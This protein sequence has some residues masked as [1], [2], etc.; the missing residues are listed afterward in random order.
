MA[1]LLE[2][3]AS[4]ASKQFLA[5]GSNLVSGGMEIIGPGT[6][7]F[8]RIAVETRPQT[9]LGVYKLAK[10]ANEQFENLCLTKLPML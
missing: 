2:C 5:L 6:E 1:N 8:N 9:E 3:V 10:L 7:I 4:T